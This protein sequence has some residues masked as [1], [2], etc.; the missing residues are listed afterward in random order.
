M[1]PSVFETASA[2]VTTLL[3]RST[4]AGT[5]LRYARPSRAAAASSVALMTRRGLTVT[6]D[7]PVLRNAQRWEIGL[8]VQAAIVACRIGSAGVA[9]MK[10]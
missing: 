6:W 5:R 8:S 2:L 4:P 10:E 3:S 7:T 9:A 1:L